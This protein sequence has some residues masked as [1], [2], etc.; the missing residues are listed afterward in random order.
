DRKSVLNDLFFNKVA[1][2]TGAKGGGTLDL[3]LFDAVIASLFPTADTSPGGDINVFG[4][5]LKT[6]RGGAIDLFAPAGSVYA[7][8]V[9]MPP[10]LADKNRSYAADL[11]I[12][13]IGGGALQALVK[14]DFLVNQGRVFTLGGGDIT[15]VSQYGNIDAGKGA[16]TAQSAPPPLLLTDEH[17]NTFVDISSSIS[18][19]GIAT[20]QTSADVPASNIYV[21]APRGY[22]D[23]G[24]AGVRSSGDFSHVGELLNANNITTA[25]GQ[26]SAGAATTIAAASPSAPATPVAKTDDLVKTDATDANAAKSLTVEL[27]GYGGD[28]QQTVTQ[29]AQNSPPADSGN[30]GRKSQSR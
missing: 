25:G 11:G 1:E 22:F 8:L 27:L 10:Y 23:A 5:Q 12:F 29:A 15:L 24:D 16:K 21:I 6:E 3:T 2:A 19:S 20:L 14:T 4:S 7:G 13:T 28:G 18:G 9:S 30:D 17:G 26:F